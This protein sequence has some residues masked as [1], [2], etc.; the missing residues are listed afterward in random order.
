[1]ASG[2][3]GVLPVATGKDPDQAFVPYLKENGSPLSVPRVRCGVV[4]PLVTAATANH[5]DHL[6]R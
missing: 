2:W 1:M 4:P 5:L 3:H 6:M